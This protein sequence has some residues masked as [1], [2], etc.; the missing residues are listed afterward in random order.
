MFLVLFQLK[1]MD[2]CFLPL[3]MAQISLNIT[4]PWS[5]VRVSA[6]VIR[7]IPVIRICRTSPSN[8]SFMA[9]AQARVLASHQ[10]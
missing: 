1:T 7:M 2:S 5:H 10:C 6:R 8:A 3:G 9:A 4:D